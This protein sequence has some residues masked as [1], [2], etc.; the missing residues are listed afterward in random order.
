MT[1]ITAVIVAVENLLPF[2]LGESIFYGR[3]LH[4]SHPFDRGPILIGVALGLASSGLGFPRG[5]YGE[6]KRRQGFDEWEPTREL[7]VAP[8]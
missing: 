6:W 2:V 8:S 5:V 7:K 4:G 1:V 3:R